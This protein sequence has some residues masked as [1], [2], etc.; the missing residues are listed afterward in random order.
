MPMAG[1]DTRPAAPMRP[2]ALLRLSRGFCAPC[3][4]GHNPPADP[5]RSQMHDQDPG[6]YNRNGIVH[7]LPSP[8]S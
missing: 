6:L 7:N 1:G 3:G 5:P 8:G 2:V 4:G